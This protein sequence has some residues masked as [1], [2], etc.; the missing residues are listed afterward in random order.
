MSHR[1]ELENLE[2]SATSIG[3]CLFVSSYLLT[4][5]EVTSRLGR[6]ELYRHVQSGHLRLLPP[7]IFYLNLHME[8]DGRPMDTVPPESNILEY[9][10]TAI[11]LSTASW[12]IVLILN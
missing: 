7:N 1:I 4:S 8:F 6:H 3:L 5:G 12:N 2:L 10:A 9:F 11:C